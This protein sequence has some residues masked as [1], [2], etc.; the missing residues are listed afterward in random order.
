MWRVPTSIL[1]GLLLLLTVPAWPRVHGEDHPAPRATDYLILVSVDGFANSMLWDTRAPMPF[2]RDQLKQ[3][4]YARDGQVCTFPTVTWPNHTTLVTGVSPAKHGVLANNVYDRKQKKRLQLIIDPLFDKDELV[5]TPTL[6]DV[7]HEAGLSTAA[8]AWPATRRAAS[9]DW[10]VPDMH[11]RDGFARYA[12]PGLLERFRRLGL[13]V[14]RY[15][16]WLSDP[17]GGA[18][19]DWLWIEAAIALY[20]TEKPNLLLIHFV[21]MDHVLHRY[22]PGSGDDL[23]VATYTDHCLRRLWYGA[24]QA[25]GP[26]ARVTMIVSSDHG[27]F[28]V[29]RSIH[30][31]VF[32]KQQFGG[33]LRP[34]I[35][36]Q[37]GSAAVYLPEGTS[38]QTRREV[39]E[40][41]RRV[42]GVQRVFEPEQFAQLGQP[43]P[44]ESPWAPDLWLAAE[45]GYSFSASGTAAQLITTGKRRGTHGFLPDQDRMRGVFVAFGAG[46]ARDVNLGKVDNRQVAPTAAALLGLSLE[47]AELPP[48]NRALAPVPAR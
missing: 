35:V 39:A 5:R 3:G 15:G 17:T 1:A 45:E 18:K 25:L 41:L 14:D 31:G 28:A 8:L 44:A 33:K 22:G 12:T 11:V 19:R 42:E 2:L 7:A 16:P 10:T 4:A 23:W 27:F 37:G 34:V 43:T 30:L 40:A 32:F 9:L 36:P 29:D 21:E 46:V 24:R 26:D 47:H 20:R 38:P 48:L 6:Y 13:P